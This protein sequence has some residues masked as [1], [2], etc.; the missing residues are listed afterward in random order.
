[1]ISTKKC[2]VEQHFQFGKFPWFELYNYP[3]WIVMHEEQYEIVAIYLYLFTDFV[4]WDKWTIFWKFDTCNTLIWINWFQ[5]QFRIWKSLAIWSSKNWLFELFN[6]SIWCGTKNAELKLKFIS[7]TSICL[8]NSV[9]SIDFVKM[10][11]LKKVNLNK[12]QLL[13]HS[14]VYT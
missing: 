14:L 11:C 2:H 9:I 1:M 7:D 6:Y 13:K 8:F 10:N 3:K 5:Y 4:R 12:I